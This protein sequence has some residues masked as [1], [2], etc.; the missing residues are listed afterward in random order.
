MKHLKLALIRQKY[1]PDGGAERFVSYALDALSRQQELEVSIV[2]R[3]WQGAPDSRYQVLR[4]DPPKWG[5]ISREAGFAR[6]ARALF[7]R[8][9][10]VQSHERIAGCHV[11]RAGDGVH[12]SW[13]AQRQ[14]ILPAWKAR[15][16]WRSRYHRYVLGAERQMFEHP[17]LKAVICNARMVRDEIAT[18]FAIDPAKLHVIYNCVDTARFNP[19]LRQQHR[20]G[21]CRTL[22]IPADACVMLYVG[23]GFERKGLAAAI[24]ALAHSDSHLVVVGKDKRQRRYQHQAKRLGLAGRVHFVGVQADPTPYYGL[25]DALLL[26]TLYDPFPNVVLEA[27]ASG[28]GVITSHTCGGAEFIEQGQQG[29]VCDALDIAALAEAIRR[30]QQPQD[31]HAM[32]QAARAR[33]EPYTQAHLVD[34]LL[35]LYRQLLD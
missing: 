17:D 26:P 3:Q 1:R 19:A 4:C 13:L 33:V 11:Y 7:E 35:A 25:A 16:M 31:A 22:G 14:R 24:A 27:M 23:S 32:G 2:T 8:F 18:R 9:D 21:L 15:W 28:I 5:R 29:F 34:N 10:L 20:A 30:F 12:H 6:Q